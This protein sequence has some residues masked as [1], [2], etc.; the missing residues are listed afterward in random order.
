MTLRHP[1]GIDE[2]VV[3]KVVSRRG[4]LHAFE[5]LKPALTALVVIDLMRASVENDEACREIVS[6]INR[7]A[8][9]LRQRGGT[10]AWVTA[11]PMPLESPVLAA[12]HGPERLRHFQDG[13]RPEDPRSQLWHELAPRAGDIHAM[14]QGYS[15]F[16]PGRCDLHAQLQRRKLDTLLIAGTVTN[17]CCESSARDAVELGY[18]V[19]MISDAN[20]GHGHGLHE[21]SLTTI[22]RCFGDVRPTAEVLDLIEGVKRPARPAPQR[23]GVQAS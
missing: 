5:S 3:A 19:I 21:A 11:A 1:S 16:F 6:P 12:I 4:R 10:V 18:R 2:K 22:Y 13:A 23:P 9:A 8:A 7:V 15:A 20:T 14:K 17:I